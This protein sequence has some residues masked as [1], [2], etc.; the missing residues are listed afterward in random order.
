MSDA[1]RMNAPANMTSDK[2]DMIMTGAAQMTQEVNE[3]I[4]AMSP[5]E[6][7]KA[8]ILLL[9][10]GTSVAPRTKTEHKGLQRYCL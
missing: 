7:E 9:R 2:M 3:T 6:L 1:E 10:S 5:A 8:T 4:A